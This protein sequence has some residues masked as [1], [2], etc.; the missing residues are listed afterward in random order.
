[1]PNHTVANAFW[2]GLTWR[3]DHLIDQFEI[4]R[5]P[6]VLVCDTDDLVDDVHRHALDSRW[7]VLQ[8]LQG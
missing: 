2:I 8:G 4:L 1:M 5:A 3:I 6:F 7:K